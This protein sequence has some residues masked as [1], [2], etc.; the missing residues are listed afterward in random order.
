MNASVI[1]FVDDA[2]D[3]NYDVITFVSKHVYF[4]QFCNH[5]CENNLLRLKKSKE[6]KILHLSAIFFCISW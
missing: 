4:Y 5:A 3:R 2:M 1:W 6:L